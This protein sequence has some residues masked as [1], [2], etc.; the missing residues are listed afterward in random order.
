MTAQ[1]EYVMEGVWHGRLL[2]ETRSAEPQEDIEDIIK[3]LLGEGV[4]DVKLIRKEWPSW[5][6]PGGYPIYYLTADNAVLC[7]KCANDNIKL[8]S[9]PDGDDQWRIVD[10]D[11]NY[12]DT[13]LYCE[14]CNGLVESAYGEPD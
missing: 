10:A 7:S 2:T 11:I 4:S 8:T 3:V 13:H 5:A 1:L 6:W 14:H 9:D 12:E